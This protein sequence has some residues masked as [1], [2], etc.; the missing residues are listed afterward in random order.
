M[1]TTTFVVTP[2]KGAYVVNRKNNPQLTMYRGQ[3]YTFNINASGHPLFI[4]TTTPYNP[5]NIY[6]NGVT[7]NGT[8]N[9]TLTFV[10]PLD[11]PNTLY[12]VCQF[13]PKMGNQINITD[14]FIP[15]QKA[16]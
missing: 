13:H 1:S 5:T 4:Q 10:V 14:L 16:R 15:I 9:G 3:T 7:G 12:Y 11:A 2:I 8:Q 6:S